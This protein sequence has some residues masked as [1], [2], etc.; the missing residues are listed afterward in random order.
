MYQRKSR[1]SKYKQERL[2]KHF[3]A[4]TTARAASELV[5]VQ[6]NTAAIYYIRLR[7][8]IASRLPS[9]QLSGE[10]EIDESYFGGVPKG[11]GDRGAAGK[12]AVFGLLKRDGEVYTAVIPNA[13]SEM[14]LPIIKQQV[15]PDSILYTDTFKR[16]N[17]LDVSDLHHMRINH[18]S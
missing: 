18:S 4:G 2:K 1:L 14:I 10:V 5:G 11:K 17:V 7:K 6:A 9:Y 12:G 3:G 8:L 13:K 16:Y 15:K